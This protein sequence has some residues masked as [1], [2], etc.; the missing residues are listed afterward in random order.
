MWKLIG[1]LRDDGVTIILTT[2]Y[3]EEAEEMADR[4]GVIAKG[5]IILVEEKAT[6]LAKLG[7]TEARFTLSQAMTALPAE[8]AGWPIALE[9]EGCT[10]AYTIDADEAQTRGLAALVRRLDEAGVDYRTLDAKRS[11][12]EDIFVGLVGQRV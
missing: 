9:N 5:E 4:I 11:S 7:R 12:L 8:L 2:H 6:L 10:L 1:Q 3:I